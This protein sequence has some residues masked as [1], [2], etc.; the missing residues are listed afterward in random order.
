MYAHAYLHLQSSIAVEYDDDMG[1][2]TVKEDVEADLQASIH[3]WK[4]DV[5]WKHVFQDL[6]FQTILQTTVW[7][8]CA[9]N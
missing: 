4:V 2:D 1:M 8:T 6:V 9:W 5:S 3:Q 7:Q